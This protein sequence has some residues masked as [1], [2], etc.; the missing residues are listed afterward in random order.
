MYRYFVLNWNPTDARAVATARS[1]SERLL[2]RE[3]GWS[4]AFESVGLAGF[5][6]GLGLGASE[7]VLLDQQAGAVFGRLFNRDMPDTAAALRIELDT[8][9][10][11]QIIQTGGRRLF[12]RYWGR[13]VA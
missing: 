7:T 3:S 2:A 12:E 11:S 9:E 5:H 4:R 13:Y 1:L 8:R 10:S 6:A